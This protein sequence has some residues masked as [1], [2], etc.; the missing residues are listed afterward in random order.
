MGASWNRIIKRTRAAAPGLAAS[1]GAPGVSSPVDPRGSRWWQASSVH[2]AHKGRLEQ[3]GLPACRGNPQQVRHQGRRAGSGRSLPIR[4][5]FD[6]ASPNSQSGTVRSSARVPPWLDRCSC[7]DRGDHHLIPLCQ[8][9]GQQ[10]GQQTVHAARPDCSTGGESRPN[11][12]P[13]SSTP[14][15]GSAENRGSYW[16]RSHSPS[17][18]R[19]LSGVVVIPVEAAVC[20]MGSCSSSVGKTI[21]TPPARGSGCRAR[22]PSGRPPLRC[23]CP[24]PRARWKM[25]SCW[26]RARHP[27]VGDAARHRRHAGRDTS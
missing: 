1:G 16:L 23:V 10:L 6:E 5:A 22:S 9:L 2:L 21:L 20:W 8:P 24:R 25:A 18:S 15:G 7:R 17:I 19:W 26:L 13:T 4:P 12:W 3:R 14:W 27:V 11:W